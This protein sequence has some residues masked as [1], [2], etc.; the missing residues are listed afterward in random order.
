MNVDYTKIIYAYFINDL[1]VYHNSK[2]ATQALPRGRSDA[3]ALQSG[4]G[5]F[6]AISSLSPLLYVTFAAW[7]DPRNPTQQPH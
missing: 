6:T 3:S 1:N 5:C 4:G 2:A 7:I